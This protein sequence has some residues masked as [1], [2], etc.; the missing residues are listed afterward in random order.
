MTSSS[1]SLEAALLTTVCPSRV[2]AELTWLVSHDDQQRLSQQ[3]LSQVV[4]V[5]AKRGRQGREQPQVRRVRMRP[6]RRLVVLRGLRNVDVHERDHSEL[7]GLLHRGGRELSCR[8]SP[9][10]ASAVR[11]FPMASKV[12]MAAS[13][14]MSPSRMRRPSGRHR[15]RRTPCITALRRRTGVLH[16]PSGP[17]ERR[18]AGRTARIRDLNRHARWGRA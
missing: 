14:D 2:R 16:G 7:F 12:W 13:G 18:S 17:R 11:C 15:P 10:R 9:P 4:G 5:E 8:S 6:T 3:L 1:L